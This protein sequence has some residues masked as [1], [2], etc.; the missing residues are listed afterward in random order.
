MVFRVWGPGGCKYRHVRGFS[1][2]KSGI[3][4]VWGS[5]LQDFKA[6]WQMILGS[7]EIGR[8]K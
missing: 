2:F 8:G 3:R 5:G 7:F 4:V 1:K 6:Y